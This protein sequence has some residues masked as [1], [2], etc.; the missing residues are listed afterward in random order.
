MKIDRTKPDVL[1]V[2]E[3][4]LEKINPVKVLVTTLSVAIQ[5]HLV[6]ILH[7]DLTI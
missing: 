6:L 2:T 3:F 7:C 1:R 5:F 4:I